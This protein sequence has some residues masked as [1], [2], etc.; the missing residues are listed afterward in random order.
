MSARYLGHPI[1][2]K[3]L[4]SLTRWPDA[5]TPLAVSRISL[6]CFAFLD[7]VSPS[8]AIGGSKFLFCKTEWVWG[9]LCAIPSSSPKH[10]VS[11]LVSASDLSGTGSPFPASQYF[12]TVKPPLPV[13]C[14]E[15][16]R[17]YGQQ[18]LFANILPSLHPRWWYRCQG[19][20]W[21]GIPSSFF[22]SNGDGLGQL[23][24]TSWT[25]QRVFNSW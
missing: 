1:N 24:F 10:C 20:L 11:T 3:S 5:T 21:N 13:S 23:S 14:V 15:L 6:R 18:W 7:R 8:G 16:L 22:S 19:F 4:D 25:F 9:V 12:F 17:S 2:S